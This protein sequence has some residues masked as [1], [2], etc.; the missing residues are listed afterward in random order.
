MKI[1][2][3]IVSFILSC[4]LVFIISYCVGYKHGVRGMTKLF[5]EKQKDEESEDTE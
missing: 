4:L 5:I 1:L 3:F 2:G